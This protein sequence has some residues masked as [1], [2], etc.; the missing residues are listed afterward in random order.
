MYVKYPEK[1]KDK[2]IKDFNIER[3]FNK[4]LKEDLPADIY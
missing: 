4:S 3:I 2:G 1:L